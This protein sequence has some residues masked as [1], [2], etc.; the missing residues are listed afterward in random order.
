MA[1]FTG[2]LPTA[3]M[4]EGRY[5]YTSLSLHTQIDANVPG[6]YRLYANMVTPR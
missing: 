5:T 6:A 2:P 1:P 3:E 4:G